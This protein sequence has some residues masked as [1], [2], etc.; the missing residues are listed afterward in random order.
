MTKLE[1]Y[2]MALSVIDRSV[3]SLAEVDSK[4]L[5]L[6]NL[7]LGM[8]TTFV[9]KASDFAFLIKKE[10]LTDMAFEDD[11]VTPSVWGSFKFGYTLPTDFLK[12]VQIAWDK[13]N[14]YAI[15][16]GKLWCNFEDPDLEY[17]PDTLEVVSEE[18]VM[19]D[20]FMSLIAYQLALHIAPI[21]DPNSD[22][23]SIA[24]QLYTLTF[25]SI[26]ENEAWNNNRPYD[27]GSTMSDV[28]TVEA[29]IAKQ[30]EESR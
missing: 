14:S 24:A 20:D 1:L 21:L 3:A 28:S 26:E 30:Y 7:N 18:Y 11:G 29:Y 23:T 8:C 5:S 19:K 2:N 22:A 27:Y 10:K 13:K 25:K 4:E 17:I 12:P 15:R 16:F 6:L 9:L